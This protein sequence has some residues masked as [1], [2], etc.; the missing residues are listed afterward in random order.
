MKLNCIHPVINQEVAYLP[1]VDCLSLVK[2]DG[3]YKWSIWVK[4]GVWLNGKIINT[5]APARLLC[6]HG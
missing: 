3:P 1:S 4:L 2:R 5:S 6:E